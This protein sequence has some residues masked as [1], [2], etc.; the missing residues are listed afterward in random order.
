MN[1][2]KTQKLLRPIKDLGG[3]IFTN[4]TIYCTAVQAQKNNVLRFLTGQK[5]R[6]ARGV[7]FLLRFNKYLFL[8]LVR[9][10]VYIRGWVSFF[11][12]VLR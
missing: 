6:S 8:A 3:R 5:H 2:A 1:H 4:S 11:P 9:T 10:G 12:F 7:R